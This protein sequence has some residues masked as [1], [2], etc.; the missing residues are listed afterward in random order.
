MKL[1]SPTEKPPAICYS[2]R[3]EY[4]F[5]LRQTLQFSFNFPAF[6][7]PLPSKSAQRGGAASGQGGSTSGQSL[8]GKE[9]ARVM[10][11][12]I[13][14]GRGRAAR[15]IHTPCPQGRR[16]AHRDS[17]VA[18]VPPGGSHGSGGPGDGGYLNSGVRGQLPPGNARGTFQ[19]L[20]VLQGAL[21]SQAKMQH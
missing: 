9:I 17:K 3:E 5:P 4:F 16:E 2:A 6:S 8:Q 20:Q 11:Q 1:P 15:T 19:Q 10:A 14:P 13:Q 21:Q 12:R 7:S 18:A